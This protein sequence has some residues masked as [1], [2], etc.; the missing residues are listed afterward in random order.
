MEKYKLFDAE[1][2]LALL[3]WD[4]EPIKSTDLVKLCADRLGWKKSTTYTML[5]KLCERDILQNKEATVTALVKREDVQKYESR[6]VLARSFDGSL[7]QF[8]TAFLDDHKLSPQE[9]EE[10]KKI[11]EEAV[12]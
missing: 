12:E 9:A 7:P 8:L 4:N 1:Y 10:L 3:V 11:I 2:K 6:A 5:K